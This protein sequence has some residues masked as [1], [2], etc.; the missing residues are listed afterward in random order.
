[1]E[2]TAAPPFFEPVQEVSM[3]RRA[4]VVAAPVIAALLAPVATV[5]APANDDPKG[6]TKPVLVVNT[7]AEAVPVSGTVTGTVNI[8]NTPNVNVANTPGVTVLNS[9]TVNAQQSGAWSFS[10][11]GPAEVQAVQS[12]AWQMGIDPLTNVVRI[13]SAT[14]V[15]VRAVEA[16]EPF[17]ADSLGNS[18]CESGSFVVPAGKRLV[19]EHVSAEASAH[20]TSEKPDSATDILFLG[21]FTIE[22]ES[23]GQTATH[24][25][26]GQEVVRE[27]S[28]IPENFFTDHFTAGG[29]VRQYADPGTVVCITVALLGSRSELVTS[30]STITGQLIPVP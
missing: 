9:P 26:V 21:H 16:P 15:L 5:A 19:I 28:A 18:S 29:P 6:P 2:S 22:T 7:T 25:L 12:G 27:I 4:H 1:M 11:A 20:R 30:Q 10:L 3:S 14:P 17:Q 23:G 24:R 8:G 13:D